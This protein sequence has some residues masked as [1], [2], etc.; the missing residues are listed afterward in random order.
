MKLQV[1]ILIFKK[2]LGDQ[3]VYDADLPFV[4][5]IP[6]F[7]KVPVSFRYI[8]SGRNTC[9]NGLSKILSTALKCLLEVARRHSYKIHRFDYIQDYII[10]DSN[11]DILNYMSTSNRT[12][13][14]KNVKTYDFQTLYTKIPQDMLKGKLEEFIGY[15]FHIKESKYINI[16]NKYAVFSDTRATK[17]SFT[18]NEF[19]T[20][21]KY[22]ID[23]AFVSFCNKVCR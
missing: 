4:Y 17:F 21:L 14:F 10:T 13:K 1:I 20:C 22:S 8:T 3:Q 16:R 2:K 19:K 5:W 7:H 12:T 11:K 15:V 18:E 23:N 6:K 9:I